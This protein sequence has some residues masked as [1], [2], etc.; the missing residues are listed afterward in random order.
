MPEGCV[1]SPEIVAATDFTVPSE[2]MLVQEVR[3]RGVIKHCGP[4][5]TNTPGTKNR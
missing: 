5:H 3:L 2:D 4:R 1:M